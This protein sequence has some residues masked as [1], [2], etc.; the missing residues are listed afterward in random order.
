MLLVV[1]KSR[2][3]S[4]VG[5]VLVSAILLVEAD[6]VVALVHLLARKHSRTLFLHRADIIHECLRDPC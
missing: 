3:A 6:V 4:A 1:D 5:R 2:R